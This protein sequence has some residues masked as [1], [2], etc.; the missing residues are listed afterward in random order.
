MDCG[1]RWQENGYVIRIRGSEYLLSED[2]W[3]EFRYCLDTLSSSADYEDCKATPSKI[4][5]IAALGLT[6]K[7]IKRRF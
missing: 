4:D 5:L 7:P 3:E 1:A 2:E 6:P